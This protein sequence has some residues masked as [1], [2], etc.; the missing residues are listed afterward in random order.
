MGFSIKFRE[1]RDVEKLMLRDSVLLI[2]YLLQMVF[3]VVSLPT[4]KQ[5]TLPWKKRDQS[6]IYFTAGSYSQSEAKT[7]QLNYIS[8]RGQESAFETELS[9]GH[10]LIK[11]GEL[12]AHSE[13]EST[14]I[15]FDFLGEE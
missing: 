13:G 2:F 5:N 12:Q 4:S 3:Q 10:C 14:Q 9:T 11:R 1:E 8:G 7:I 15:A 6:V